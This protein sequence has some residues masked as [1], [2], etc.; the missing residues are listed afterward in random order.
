MSKKVKGK[1]LTHEEKK[2]T[3]GNKLCYFDVI[4]P[5]TLLDHC[6]KIKEK[7]RMEEEISPTISLH[8]FIAV[9]KTDEQVEQ[10]RLAILSGGSEFDLAK[11]DDK[12]YSALHWA[13]KSLLT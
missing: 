1:K 2:I 7:K 10:L 8:R 12:G 5:E 9:C 6:T 4:F 11:T 3:K 13:G